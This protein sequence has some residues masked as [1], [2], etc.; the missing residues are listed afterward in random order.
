MWETAIVS[1]SPGVTTPSEVTRAL[2]K[3]SFGFSVEPWPA[4]AA[5]SAAKTAQAKA[6]AAALPPFLLPLPANTA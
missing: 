1:T 4:G 5:A 2:R 6:A 3:T